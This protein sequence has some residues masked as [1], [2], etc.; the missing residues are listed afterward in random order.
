MVLNA[1]ASRLE[2]FSLTA[3]AITELK[4][5]K[6]KFP[7]EKINIHELI[8]KILEGSQNTLVQR[9]IS[10]D[11][12]ENPGLAIF[13][14][15]EYL[16]KMCLKGIFENAICFSP[17]AGT[18]WVSI[19]NTEGNILCEISDEGPGFSEVAMKNLF[20]LFQHG[21]SHLDQNMGLDLGLA[22]MIM[23]AH[24]GK[25]EIENRPEKGAVVKLE[26]PGGGDCGLLRAEC[27]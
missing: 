13:T 22:K 15:N 21:V 1:S 10:L 24:E 12:G 8:G 5:M 26:F 25:I 27:G 3:L 16:V 6:R 20:K 2:R 23:E 18:I 14:G 19:K 4:T 9:D 17:P 11:Y 7:L